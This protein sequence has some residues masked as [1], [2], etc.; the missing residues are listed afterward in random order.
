M[1]AASACRVDLLLLLGFVQY[2]IPYADT[3]NDAIPISRPL[4]LMRVLRNEITNDQ[5]LITLRRRQWH[6]IKDC[7]P[8]FLAKARLCA[9]GPR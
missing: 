2:G 4:Y 5:K 1:L 9:S 7:A 3:D 8:S 6:T